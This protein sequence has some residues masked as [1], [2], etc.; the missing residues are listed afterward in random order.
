MVTNFAIGVEGVRRIASAA[1]L[2]EASASLPDG[3]YTTLLVR[4]GHRVLDFERHLARL[5]GSSPSAAR[6]DPASIAAYLLEAIDAA[7]LAAVRA[8]LTSSA[9][10]LFASLE[11][12]EPL[13]AALYDRGV[14]CETVALRRSS[15]DRKDTRFLRAAAL[16]RAGL[17]ADVH[18]GL[19]VDAGGAFLEGLSSNFFGVREAELRTAGE[20]VLPGVTRRR[21]L[22]LAAGLLTVRLE[23]IGRGSLEEIGEAFLTSASRGVLPVVKIDGRTIGSGDPGERTRKLGELLVAAQD[24][25]AVALSDLA[26]APQDES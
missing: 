26:R 22:E 17:G 12:Y 9:R 15:P 2:A 16:A 19:L 23:P 25:E 1:S 8:R 4:E 7:Q 11:P 18:E 3:S 24:R 10:G 14:A 6:I 20:G 21:V 5:T 13:P